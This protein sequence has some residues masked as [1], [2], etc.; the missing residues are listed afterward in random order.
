V[1]TDTT[2]TYFETDQDD[3]VW[4]DQHGRVVDTDIDIDIDTNVTAVVAVTSSWFVIADQICGLAVRHDVIV[5]NPI[6]DA[7]PLSTK[8]KT[9]PRSF[10][11]AQA[12]QLLAFMTYDD[13]AIARDVPALVAT[14]LATG[15]RIGEACAALW[16]SVDLT[17][18]TLRWKRLSCG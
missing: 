4:R 3:P 13:Q 1:A 16:R 2:S 18:Q 7:S 14:M 12:L 5:T 8:P 15:L 6:R 9:P 10:S 17:A 11:E